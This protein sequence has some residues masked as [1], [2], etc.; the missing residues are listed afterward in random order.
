M[1]DIFLFR[2]LSLSDLSVARFQITADFLIAFAGDFFTEEIED[3]VAIMLFKLKSVLYPPDVTA[4]NRRRYKITR[5][6]LA[7]AYE[8]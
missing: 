4:I 3:T 1:R 7:F 8:H 6:F 5:F 2:F